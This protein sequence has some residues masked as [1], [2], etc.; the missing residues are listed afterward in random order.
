MTP[1]GCGWGVVRALV[2]MT[3][4][5]VGDRNELGASER[6][7]VLWC[8]CRPT[9]SCGERVGVGVVVVVVSRVRRWVVELRCAVLLWSSVMPWSRL[10]AARSSAKSGEVSL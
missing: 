7:H 8:V 6:R 4:R 9:W 2:A 5:C 10:P 3:V 1:F